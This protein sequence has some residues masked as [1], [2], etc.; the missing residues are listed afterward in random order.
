MFGLEFRPVYVLEPLR[1]PPTVTGISVAVV[2]AKNTH[3]VYRYIQRVETT[4]WT[5]YHTLMKNMDLHNAIA[6]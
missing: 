1:L 5:Q 2:G 3:I 6:K 4:L